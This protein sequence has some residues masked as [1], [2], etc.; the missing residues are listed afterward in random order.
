MN[1][2]TREGI[3]CP[4]CKSNSLDFNDISVLCIKCK[5]EFPIANNIPILINEEQSIFSFKS[6]IENS[7]VFFDLSSKGKLLGRI[8]RLMPQLQTNLHTK[9]NFKFIK[10]Q[11]QQI[12]NPRVLIIGAGTKGRG[13]A[14]F[15]KTKEFLFTI[16]DVCLGPIIN[17]VI[18]AH[19]IPYEKNFFDCVIV[20]AVLE[21][22]LNPQKCVEEIH[23]IL[24]PN[25]FVYSET[26]FMQQVHGGAYDFT[27][28]TKSGHRW[29]FKEFTEIYSGMVAGPASGLAWSIQYFLL[30]L[31]PQSRFF[32][33]GIKLIL[34]CLLFWLKYI[35]YSFKFKLIAVDSANS[36]FFLGR[37]AEIS[38]SPK[39]MLIYYNQ[40]S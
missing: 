13:I 31:L 29:L 4:I 1:S 3:V 17:I 39:E 33:L 10:N 32:A 16:S 15:V 9:Q 26:P 34:R 28:F 36:Y 19:S 12:K 27:R 37:K 24:K 23:R 7:N 25:G 30:S 8:S 20:Q 2:L 38:I 18:D 22:V 14:D 11:L 40:K 6:I 5:K 21:H 35:D